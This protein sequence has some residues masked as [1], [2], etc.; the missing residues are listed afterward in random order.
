MV[1]SIFLYLNC[2]CRHSRQFQSH[3]CEVLAINYTWFLI[4]M[5]WNIFSNIITHS[6]NLSVITSNNSLKQRNPSFFHNNDSWNRPHPKGIMKKL[7]RS[8]KG[9]YLLHA[10]F[11]ITPRPQQR[12]ENR[13]SFLMGY[14]AKTCRTSAQSRCS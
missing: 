9:C 5:A 2:I 1:F 13:L 11:F 7:T 4:V 14:W 12:H 3:F 8:K 10:I 6:K